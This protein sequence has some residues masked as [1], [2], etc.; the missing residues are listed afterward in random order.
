M[1]SHT[2]EGA[3][4]REVGRRTHAHTPPASHTFTGQMI[5]T[6]ATCPHDQLSAVVI[7]VLSDLNSP[8]LVDYHN[9]GRSSWQLRADRGRVTPVQGRAGD[10]PAVLPHVVCKNYVVLDDIKTLI[11][12]LSFEKAFEE[13]PIAK[14]QEHNKPETWDVRMVVDRVKELWNIPYFRYFNSNK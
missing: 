7:V 11:C 1:N 8:R 13:F 12:G 14:F 2:N 10:F 6:S 5:V 3:A 9:N 4:A